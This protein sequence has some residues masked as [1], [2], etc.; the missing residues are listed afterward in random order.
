MSTG[1]TPAPEF[2][3]LA[4][5]E[6]RDLAADRGLHV[7]IAGRDGESFALSMDLRTN[8]VNFVIREGTVDDAFIG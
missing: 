7:R 5:S 2:V 4:E 3:G 1:A 8:R 6:A